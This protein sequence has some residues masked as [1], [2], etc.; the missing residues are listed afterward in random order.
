MLASSIALSSSSGANSKNIPKLYRYKFLISS[1]KFRLYLPIC[2][3]NWS[4]NSEYS[5]T[6]AVLRTIPSANLFVMYRL[7]FNI[8]LV[9]VL[10]LSAANF[11]TPTNAS[12]FGVEPS[13]ASF[14]P[15]TVLIISR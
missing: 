3:A 14:K 7:A 8:C 15:V 1:S 11:C 13:R 2:I 10:E 5:K 9:A 12:G 4:L 6:S